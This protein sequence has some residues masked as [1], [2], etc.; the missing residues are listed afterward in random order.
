MPIWKM[1]FCSRYYKQIN[2][3][4]MGTIM[5]P[6][7]ANLFVAYVKH[8]F[9]NQYNGPKPELCGRYIDDCI[10]AI[11]SS[12]EELDQFITSIQVNPTRIEFKTT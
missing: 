11:S 1:N 7:Y 10:G 8:Q 4:A 5:A 2:G 12:R 3:V 6:S 9:F